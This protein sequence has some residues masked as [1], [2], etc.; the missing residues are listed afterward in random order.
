MASRDMVAE[1]GWIAPSGYIACRSGFAHPT[2]PRSTEPRPSEWVNAPLE[3]SLAQ[4]GALEIHQVRHVGEAL[5]QPPRQTMP[6]IPD[7]SHLKSSFTL[8][9]TGGRAGRSSAPGTWERATAHRLVGPQHEPRFTKP[10]IPV[11]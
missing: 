11:S 7:R 10:T 2:M 6:V 4:L 5:R 1:P 9:P 8:R 3:C